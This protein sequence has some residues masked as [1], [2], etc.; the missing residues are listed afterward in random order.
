M[1]EEGGAVEA[2]E[3][4]EEEVES[5]AV[6]IDEEELED[7]EVEEGETVVEEDEL[8]IAEPEPETRLDGC[9]PITGREDR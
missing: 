2:T 1:A 8:E 6:D 5:A 4:V 7:E 9:L 3:V